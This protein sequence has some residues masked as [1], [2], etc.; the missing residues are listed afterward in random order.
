[1]DYGEDGCLN[2]FTRGQA[3]R[4]REQIGHFRRLVAK[5]GLP[6]SASASHHRGRRSV[7]RRGVY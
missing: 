3:M 4:V 2:T 5:Q 7:P 6:S 1:M